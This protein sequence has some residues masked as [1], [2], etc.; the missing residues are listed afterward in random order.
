LLFFFAADE[1]F[2]AVN[3]R[4][5][6]LGDGVVGRLT[7]ELVVACPRGGVLLGK[8]NKPRSGA[9]EMAVEASLQKGVLTDLFGSARVQTGETFQIE[10][11]LVGEKFV[12]ARKTVQFAA[13]VRASAADPKTPSQRS[14]KRKRSPA[15]PQQPQ[16]PSPQQPQQPS[17]Q[18][19]SHPSASQHPPD[20]QFAAPVIADL[21]AA[22]LRA[23]AGHRV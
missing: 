8:L 10:M 20:P 21:Y 12:A 22:A 23:A 15:Q 14:R 9:G 16:Q 3:G 2:E 5:C 18:H 4:A 13:V 17:P 7:T 11:E 1:A 19:P 6:V